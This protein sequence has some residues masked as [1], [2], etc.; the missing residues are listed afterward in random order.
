LFTHDLSW[1]AQPSGWASALFLGLLSTS[2]A[3]IFF[4]RGLVNVPVSK[5]VTLTLAEPLT[6]SALGIMILGERLSI[7][8]VLGIGLIFIALVMLSAEKSNL[9]V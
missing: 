8:A 3:Y 2:L 7:M 9:R 6:A 5:A 4:A 1:L